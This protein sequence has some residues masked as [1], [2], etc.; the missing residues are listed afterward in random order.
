[1]IIEIK[2]I[3]GEFLYSSEATNLRE[4]LENAVRDSAD[5]SGANL[6]RADLSGAN[7]SGANLSGANL[8][9]ANL[10]G[11]NISRA[12]LYDDIKIN[13]IPIQISTPIYNVIIFDSHLKIGCKFYL[14]SEWEKFN[15]EEISSLET[16]SSVDALAWWS[17]WKGP[18]MAIC[19]AEGRQ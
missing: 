18:I 1:M 10:S 7:L 13:L 3:T 19:A 17:R 9:G 4:C 16:R 2:S 15:D 11:A 6:S 14:I 5:L 12:N 8:Y